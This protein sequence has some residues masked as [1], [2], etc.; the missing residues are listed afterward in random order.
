MRGS[1]RMFSNSYEVDAVKS[2]KIR[3]RVQEMYTELW[4]R[5]FLVDGEGRGRITLKLIL[6]KCICYRDMRYK[7]LRPGRDQ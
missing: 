3:I 2:L 4:W 1:S 5:T 7:K 6:G